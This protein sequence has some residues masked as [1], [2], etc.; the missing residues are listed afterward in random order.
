MN[1]SKSIYD[2]DKSKAEK[3]KPVSIF[4]E[5]GIVRATT[6]PDPAPKPEPAAPKARE[7]TNQRIL[8]IVSSARERLRGRG[9]PELDAEIDE[10][11]EEIKGWG[12]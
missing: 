8:R 9:M 3:K 4:K 2:E 1:T 6:S 7:T 11:I 10:L 5:E 12:Q